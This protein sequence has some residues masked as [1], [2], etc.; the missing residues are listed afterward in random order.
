MA[1]RVGA[2]ACGARA[3]LVFLLAIGVA[4]CGG[5]GSSLQW[6]ADRSSPE[7]RPVALRVLRPAPVNLADAGIEVVA[8]APFEGPGGAEIADNLARQ[9]GTE[10]PLRALPPEVG[11]DRLMKSGVSVS[12][13]A[14]GSSLRPLRERGGVDG[15]VVGRVEVFQVEGWEKQSEDTLTP[16]KTG[17]YGFVRNEEGKIAWRE[18]VEY[19]RVPLYCRT[20][21]GTVAA[22][23]RVWGADRPSAVATVRRELTMEMPSFCYRVDVTDRLRREAQSR[24]LQKL[25]RELNAR[26]LQDVVPGVESVT[27][28]FEVLPSGTEPGLVYRNELALVYVGRGEWTRAREMWTECLAERP[29]L[30]AAHYNLARLEQ[31][32]GHTTAAAGLLNKAL[33]LR[34]NPLY[35]AAL[36]EVR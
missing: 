32:L 25:F 31:A 13:E 2:M 7:V 11:R 5:A 16:H 17:E 22:V 33:A 34:P 15:V 24:L 30:A 12:W 8:V 10:G 26:F 19:A 1:P 27:V 29:D 20:D 3:A 36:R 14:A 4:A 21:R 35:R 18:K 6:P 9:L 28:P 23:Y